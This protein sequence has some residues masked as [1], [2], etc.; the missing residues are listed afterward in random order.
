MDIQYDILWKY[1][2][3]HFKADT[4]GIHGIMHWK[5]VEKF[6]E[7]LAQQCDAD[8]EV[9]RLFAVLHDSGR[10][11]DGLDEGHGYRSADIALKL[12]G[13]LYDLDDARFE[14]LYYACKYHSERACATDVTVGV[15]WD[16]DRLDLQ[17]LDIEPDAQ[18]MSTK[19]GM[20]LAHKL[21]L[22]ILKR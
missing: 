19:A 22:A 21:R 3:K 12:K 8:E 13:E 10:L 14:L 18:F 2:K 5:N 16:A 4:K 15:C 1:I 9:V 11:S 7:R 20:K 17:R 6:G